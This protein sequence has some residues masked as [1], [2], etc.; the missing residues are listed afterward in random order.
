MFSNFK[1]NW[2]LYVMALIN[3]Q[4]GGVLLST[5]REALTLAHIVRNTP[6]PARDRRLTDKQWHGIVKAWKSFNGPVQNATHFALC[7]PIGYL[8]AQETEI[9]AWL[10]Y[11]NGALTFD[12][13]DDEYV[14]E[15]SELLRTVRPT[16]CIKKKIVIPAPNAPCPC[17]ATNERNKR[18]KY[19]KC[20]GRFA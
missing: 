3:L 14:Y 8:E 2:G 4:G 11:E 10:E 17:G 13:V 16:D 15:N 1:A 19:K 9:N 6:L 7:V 12:I 5:E 18:I 20:C